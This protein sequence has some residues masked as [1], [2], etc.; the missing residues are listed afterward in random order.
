MMIR[1]LEKQV[2]PSEALLSL[3]LLADPD[4]EMITGYFS[5]S[6]LFVMELEETLDHQIVGVI[7]LKQIAQDTFEIMNLAVSDD[8]QRQGIGQ[9]LLEYVIGYS[10]NA[11]G[12]SEIKIATGNSSIGALRLYQK[13]GFMI[14]KVVRD[15][16]INHYP[17]PIYEEGI[18]CRDRIELVYRIKSGCS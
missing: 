7:V 18:Q 14:D 17:E 15:Y 12:I 10:A 1:Q 5:E 6:I 8:Y 3:L 16:F 13:C 9:E 2:Y 4:Q 11:A